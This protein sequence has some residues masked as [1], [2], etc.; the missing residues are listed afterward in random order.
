MLLVSCN[1]Y[2]RNLTSLYVGAEEMKIWSERK[3]QLFKP[4]QKYTSGF[5]KE[6]RATNH[7]QKK[8]PHAVDSVESEKKVEEIWRL[9]TKKKIKIKLPS[10]QRQ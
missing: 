9:E 5:W 1:L 3:F 6:I 4:V 2:G 10:Q 8:L 7:T